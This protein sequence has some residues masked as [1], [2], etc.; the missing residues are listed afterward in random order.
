MPSNTGS[1]II[2]FGAG[3]TQVST[4][5]TTEASISSMSFVSAWIMYGDSTGSNSV[6]NHLALQVR[7]LCGTDIAGTGF[8]IWAQTNSTATGQYKVRWVWADVA[9]TVPAPVP[10]WQKI[11]IGFAS[12]TAAA[13][14]Q[15]VTILAVGPRQIITGLRS[16]EHTS[17]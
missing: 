13:T 8:T 3:A 5:V 16:E 11:T 4:V 2:D 17:E 1:A 7:L 14:T 6:A 9:P 10:F 15:T 12:L